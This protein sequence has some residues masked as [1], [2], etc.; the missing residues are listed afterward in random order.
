M[1]WLRVDDAMWRNRK[2]MP[3]SPLAKCLW[4][5][6][7]GY[8]ADQLTDGR[9]TLVDM[10][11]VATATGLDDWEGPVKELFASGLMES[12]AE[13]PYIIH[14]YLDYNPS[15]EQVLKERAENARRQADWKSG[16]RHEA[17][18]T[19]ATADSITNSVS[20]KC[21]VPVPVPV[22]FITTPDGVDE[23]GA[24]A[25]EPEATK[26]KPPKKDRVKAGE[27]ALY[28]WEKSHCRITDTQIEEINKSVT[29]LTKW[30]RVV[31]AWLLHGFSPKNVAGPLEWY[32]KGLPTF[33]KGPPGRKAASRETHYDEAELARV[34][35]AEPKVSE[36][37]W[38]AMAAGLS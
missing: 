37:E 19:D 3:V 23:P 29:D 18:P 14:D 25:V 1:P 10:R 33:G 16:K 17:T 31:D 36:E 13:C 22:P 24:M 34:R 12:D 28:H 8:S 4:V 32:R 5:W 2:V 38:R 27:A 35:A 20:N 21:P 9:L 11:Q 6:A 7:M 30:K 15:R 26:P